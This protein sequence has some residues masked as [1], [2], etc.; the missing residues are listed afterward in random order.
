M[1][2]TGKYQVVYTFGWYLP[3]V[4]SDVKERKGATPVVLSHTP[5][6]SGTGRPSERN[7]DTYGQW[8]KDAAES[9]FTI[10]T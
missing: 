1:E 10:L 9:R 5:V 6:T 7:T 3:Q 8:A 4:Y 2:A